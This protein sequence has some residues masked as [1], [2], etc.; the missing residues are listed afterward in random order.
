MNTIGPF[1]LVRKVGTEDYET[2]S[3]TYAVPKLYTKGSATNLKNR[4]NK[5]AIKHG[6]A[7]RHEIVSV[8]FKLL[9]VI[10]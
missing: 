6:L 7:R 9:E 2:G 3:G 1:F 8:E 10:K 4:R 5:E